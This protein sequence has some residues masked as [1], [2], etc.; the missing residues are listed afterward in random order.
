MTLAMSSL[1]LAQQETLPDQ[2]L[3]GA[4][5]P[6]YSTQRAAR[7]LGTPS[8][9]GNGAVASYAEF[10]KSGAPKEIRRGLFGWRP[11]RLADAAV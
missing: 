2:F 5:S 4:L 3:T 9:L 10:D 1:G 11:G 7:F 8:N 6:G